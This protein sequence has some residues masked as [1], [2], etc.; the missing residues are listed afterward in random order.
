MKKIVVL[1]HSHS[2]NTADMAD[3]VAEGAADKNIEVILSSFEKGKVQDVLTADAVGMG[4]YATA[5]EEIDYK[6]V[7]PFL[8][9]IENDMKDKPIVLFGSYGWGNGKY[10]RDWEQIMH[11]MDVNLLVEGYITQYKPDEKALEDCRNLGKLLK[12]AAQRN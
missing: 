5:A 10:M 4:C 2:G 1:Y 3:A 9:A 12:Q 8:K 11:Q 7:V 6:A